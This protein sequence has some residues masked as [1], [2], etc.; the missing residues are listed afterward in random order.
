[1]TDC[2][3]GN[4]D[5]RCQGRLSACHKVQ[6]IASALASL[7]CISQQYPLLLA[8]LEARSL[9]TRLEEVPDEDAP[10][11]KRGRPA[12]SSAPATKSTKVSI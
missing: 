10:P 7:L 3:T 9:N 2:V 12:A 5:L 6:K 11:K 4:I 1:M 8:D